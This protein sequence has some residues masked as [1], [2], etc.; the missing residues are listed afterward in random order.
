[1]RYLE[2]VLGLPDALHDLLI[3]EL[4][5]LGAEGFEQED[6]EL[7]VSLPAAMWDDV[8]RQWLEGWLLAQGVEAPIQ[9]RLIEP[10]SATIM[11]RGTHAL[12]DGRIQPDGIEL[13]YLN[14]PVEETFFRMLRH[15]EFDVA[16][17]SLSS[18]VVSLFAP[19]RPFV[20]IPVF[21]SRFFRHSC[22]FVNADAGIREPKDLAGK[23]IASMDIRWHEDVRKW[24]PG[25]EWI[26]APG[27]FGVFDPGINALSIASRILPQRLFV[28]SAELVYLIGHSEI[29]L[30]VSLPSRRADRDRPRAGY[31]F[32]GTAPAPPAPP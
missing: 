11:P 20:A 28:R 32:R 19:D 22:I 25:Q 3:A 15:R 4:T 9:E 12:L 29:G 27:G 6:E 31:D 5:D 2:L 16:E 14:L 18:Y 17:M 21:P 1:M 26:W 23:R 7:R 24:H 10:Q 13:N 8:K 30:A